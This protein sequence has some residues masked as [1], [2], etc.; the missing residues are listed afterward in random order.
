MDPLMEITGLALP[1]GVLSAHPERV[2]LLTDGQVVQSTDAWPLGYHFGCCANAIRA[3]QVELVVDNTWV[4]HLASQRH[5]L[6]LWETLSGLYFHAR[7]PETPFARGLVAAVQR[8]KV[9]CC[10]RSSRTQSER[11]G[12]ALVIYAAD[13]VEISLMVNGPPT[14]KQTWVSLAGESAS[15]RIARETAQAQARHWPGVRE[16]SIA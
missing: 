1:Y 14:F 5:G 15:A 3:G 6:T 8:G 10:P 7:L 13:V 12:E 16:D 4:E 9:G 2:E 11:H